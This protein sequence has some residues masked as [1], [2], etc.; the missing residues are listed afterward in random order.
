MKFLESNQRYDEYDGNRSDSILGAQQ[1]PQHYNIITTPDTTHS[2]L[3][4]ARNNTWI[5]AH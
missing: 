4:I 3:G 2:T 1:R 5:H